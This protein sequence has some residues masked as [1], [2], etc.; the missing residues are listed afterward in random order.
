MTAQTPASSPAPQPLSRVLVGSLFLWLP[1]C[2]QG[3]AEEPENSPFASGYNFTEG[4]EESGDASGQDDAA[5]DPDDSEAAT[6]ADASD[7]AN[8]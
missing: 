3:L 5:T 7:G 1:A 8:S 6:T 4:N 2:Y